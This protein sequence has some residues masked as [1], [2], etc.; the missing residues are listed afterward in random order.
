[1]AF[2]YC[3][4]GNVLYRVI[5]DERLRLAVINLICGAGEVWFNYSISATVIL[6]IS[7]FSSQLFITVGSLKSLSSEKI[8]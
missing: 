1:M 5:L 8:F 6:L 4:C 7:F 2:Y 3:Y